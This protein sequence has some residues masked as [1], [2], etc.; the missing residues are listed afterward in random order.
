MSLLR[1]KIIRYFSKGDERSIKAKQ[2][3]IASFGIKG[4]SIFISL[5][6]VPLT[7]GYVNSTQ[8]G[9]WLTISSILGWFSYFDMGLTHGFRN[10]FAEAKAKHNTSLARTFVS[11]TYIAMFVIFF[12]VFLCF[13]VLNKYCITWH[14]VLNVDASLENELKNVFSIVSLFFCLQMI[15]KPISTLIIAD[16]RPAFASMIDTIS[17]IIILLVIYILT[18]STEGSLVLLSMAVSAIPVLV[19][20]V[21]SF[22]LYRRRYSIYKPSIQYYERDR[23]KDVVGLGGKFFII[24]VSSI[25]VFQTMNILISNTKGPDSVTVYNITY[26][27]FFVFNMLFG[28]MLVPFW[29]AFTDAYA[30]GDYQWMKSVYKK[31]THYSYMMLILIVL[32]LCV[33]NFVYDIWLNGQ[34]DVPFKV[35]L[36]MAIYIICTTMGCVPVTLLNG[37][38]KIKLQ[39]YVHVFYAIITIPCLFFLLENYDL[40]IGLLFIALNPLSHLIIST[41]QINKVLNKQ[42]NGIWSK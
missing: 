33:S 40:Y 39:M 24:Q 36:A 6:L 5:V 1:K 18:K 12:I 27:C 30:K 38:G 11:T 10:K 3:I 35:S 31:L 13:S 28:I 9:L 19:L 7:I 29:S 26:K 41:I 34:V 16:Q 25:L 21:S 23:I 15:L 14:S 17:Q 42:A 22:Y 2:N 32:F 4:L 8:Y 37:I 20:I